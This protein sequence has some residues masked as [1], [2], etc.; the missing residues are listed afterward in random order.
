LSL[1]LHH[2]I[3]KYEELEIL[4]PTLLDAM[5]RAVIRLALTKNF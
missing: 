1:S 2:E 5:F 4:L 3:R